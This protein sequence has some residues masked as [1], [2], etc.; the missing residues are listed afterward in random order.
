M[1]KQ[2]IL[3]IFKTNDVIDNIPTV[4]IRNVSSI[5]AHVK[6]KLALSL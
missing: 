4:F 6:G 3:V 5:V 2:C 1:S